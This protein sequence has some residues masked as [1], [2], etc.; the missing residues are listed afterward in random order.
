MPFKSCFDLSDVS[1]CFACMFICAPQGCLVHVCMCTTRMPGAPGYPKRPLDP[2]QLST[3]IFR[4]RGN[5][6]SHWTWKLTDLAR[7]E[8]QQAP[9]PTPGF[10]VVLG[11]LLLSLYFLT[12]ST[13]LTEPSPWVPCFSLLSL[14]LPSL[15]PFFWGPGTHKTTTTLVL[16]SEIPLS[17]P[18]EGWY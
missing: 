7:L 8:S 5:R 2:L 14:F 18:P 17:L 9:N 1:E 10:Y 6:L 11:N 4:N 12:V 16:N 13:L 3:C 15:L